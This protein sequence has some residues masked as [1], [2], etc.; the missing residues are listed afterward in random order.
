MGGLGNAL[1][2]PDMGEAMGKL[3]GGLPGL[4]GGGNIPPELAN[5]MNKKKK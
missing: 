4:P 1:G 3:G 5:F 2:G